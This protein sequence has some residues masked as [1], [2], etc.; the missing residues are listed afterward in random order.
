MLHKT[1][2]IKHTVRAKG[3]VE[4]RGKVGDEETL[5]RLKS[6]TEPEN[7]SFCPVITSI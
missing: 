3:L 7:P 1:Q 4:A 6:E 5:G 2:Q